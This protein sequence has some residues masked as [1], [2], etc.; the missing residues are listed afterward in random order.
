MTVPDLRRVVA[1]YGRN[2][3][4]DPVAL[5]SALRTTAPDADPADIEQLVVVAASGVLEV[6]RAARR[7]GADRAD[8][9]AAAL[10]AAPTGTRAT[11]VLAFADALHALPDPTA[12]PVPT[13]PPRPRP[14]PTPRVSWDDDEPDPVR[15]LDPPARRRRR[16]WPV[17]VGA[18]IVVVLVAV[19][20][21]VFNQERA[22]PPPDRYAVDQVAQRYRALGAALLDGALG[23]A[24]IAPEPGLTERVSCSFGTWSLQLSSYDSASR[25]AGVREQ[26]TT[27]D[28]TA[29]RE[30]IT[31]GPG[32]AAV[33]REVAEPGDVSLGNAAATLYWDSDLPRPVSASVRT[34]DV[35]MPELAAFWD[36]R[37]VEG[38]PRPDLPGREFRAAPLWKLARDFINGTDATCGDVPA[39]KLFPNA[40]EQH[41][42]RY[43][44]GLSVEFALLPGD[45]QLFDYRTTFADPDGV[46]PGSQRLGS[47]TDGTTRGQMIEYIASGDGVAYLYFDDPDVRAFGLMYGANAD[48]DRVKTFWSDVTAG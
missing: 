37:R 45:Q 13:A 44:N 41:R 28:L 2:V 30:A 4:G 42:C 38:P 24:P 6:L 10:D 5:R 46:Q 34:T 22:A 7:D 27:P 9:L 43:S 31:R 26:Q 15:P 16:A 32:S 20:A 18:G 19:L 23:C 8:A 11:T 33:M 40:V 25:L 48:Q 36:T 3:L 35:P 29:V 21:V 14:R 47:W 17:G 39:D 1:D 12:D